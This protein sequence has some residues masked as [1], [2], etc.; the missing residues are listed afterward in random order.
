MLWM[1]L[2]A[3]DDPWGG[4][5]REPHRLLL[6]ELGVLEGG[7]PLDPVDQEGWQPHLFHEE[8]LGKNRPDLCR[9]GTCDGDRGGLPGWRASPRFR[10][11]LVCGNCK[12]HPDDPVRPRR[13]FRNG[14]DRLS[15]EPGEGGEVCPLV[16]IRIEIVIDEDGIPFFPRFLLERE[17]DEISESSGRHRILVGKEAVV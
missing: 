12:R 11:V 10:F 7:Q 9:Q 5:R 17:G 4:G 3:G 6:V 1:I 8:S 2:G 14:V 13:L 15:G 16:R